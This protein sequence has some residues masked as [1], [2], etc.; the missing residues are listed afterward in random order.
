MERDSPSSSATWNV[1]TVVGDTDPP[2]EA[3]AVVRMSTSIGLEGP[4]LPMT[5]AKSTGNH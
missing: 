3:D 4:V 5:D 1:V 2:G